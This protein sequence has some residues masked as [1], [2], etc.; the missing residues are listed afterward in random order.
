MIFSTQVR[1]IRATARGALAE[2][3]MRS[4]R[5]LNRLA[6]LAPA[7]LCA[8]AAH[9]NAADLPYEAKDRHEGVASCAGSNCHGSSR[10]AADVSI[11]Q[12]EYLTWER[13]D[14]HSNA[15]KLLLSPAGKRIATNLG[16]KSAEGAPECLTCHAD[17]VS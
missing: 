8:L 6:R 4:F 13:K 12:N 7:A 16:L 11:L 17:F 5:V 9:A 15:Y 2:G 3:E 14:A 10:A 1:K